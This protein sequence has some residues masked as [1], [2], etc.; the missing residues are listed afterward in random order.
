M[1]HLELKYF[2]HTI[3]GMYL[4]N[5]TLPFQTQSYFPRRNDHLLSSPMYVHFSLIT[6][7]PYCN[8][9]SLW[10]ITKTNFNDWDLVGC[11]A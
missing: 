4:L 9:E 6:L 10:Y 5:S 11:G 3:D 8:N 7:G 1:Y 2:G